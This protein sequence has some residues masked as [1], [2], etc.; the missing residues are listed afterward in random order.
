MLRL[1]DWLLP[2]FELVHRPDLQANRRQQ[3]LDNL[4]CGSGTASEERSLCRCMLAHQ[5]GQQM[6]M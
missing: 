1:Q 6:E 5:L 3:L 2:R 4:L